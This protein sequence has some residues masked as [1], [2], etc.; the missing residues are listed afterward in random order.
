MPVP[1]SRIRVLD[2]GPIKEGAY[3]LYWMIAARRPHHS[4]ALDRALELCR[5][6][7]TPLLVLEALRVGYRWASDRLHRFALDGMADNRAGFAEVGVT[8]YAYVE[9][10]AGAGA[11][12]LEA[13]AGHACAIVT[14]DY[15]CF[16]LPR[17]IDAAV[18]RL[19]GAL[20]FEAVDGNGLFPMRAAERTFTVAHSFRRHLQKTLAPHL[21]D[22]PLAEPFV[23]Y[24]HDPVDVPKKIRAKWPP[25]EDA[26]LAGEG[27]DALPIDHE[28][29]PVSYRG[30][31]AAGT[32]QL[33]DFFEARLPKYHEGRNHPDDDAAS[34]LSPWLHWGH[35]G[36]WQIFEALRERDGWTPKKLAKPNGK[37][38]GWWNMSPEAEAFLDELVTWRELGFNVCTTTD[39][40][41]QL[42]SIPEWAT[43]TLAEH[44][45]DPRPERYTLQE[46]EEAKT[47]DG[48]WNAAQRQLREEGRIHNYLRMLWGKKILEWTKSA[49][50]AAEV[51]I[52]LNDRY[53]VDGRDPNSYSG[54]F[55]VLGRHDRAWGPERPIYGKVRYMTS[56]STRKKLH[57][58]E[59]LAKWSGE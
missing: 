11:G 35:V 19:D 21:E 54:I 32:E 25:A 49:E 7:G 56:E 12:L 20:H 26:L 51:M 18:D 15:P 38:E 2:D 52:R 22:P 40:Y 58:K 16:F 45:D 39:D 13:L 14:D 44:A 24:D 36:T 8:H 10:K 55:W 31:Y 47:G 57:L 4:H 9:P 50:E 3:V 5:E 27:L 42:S 34:G 23:D 28:V 53:A 37:R 46:M 33:E 30:G 41:D 6:T 29:G 48:I 1:D 59:Y 43:E 17:M